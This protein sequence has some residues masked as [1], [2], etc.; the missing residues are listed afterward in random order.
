MEQPP[1]ALG[2]RCDSR[3]E[4]RSPWK[5][6]AVRKNVTVTRYP[7]WVRALRGKSGVYLVRDRVTKQVIYVGRGRTCIKK[8]IVR[9][10]QAW[11]DRN[12]L[13][14][15]YALFDREAVEVKVYCIRPEWVIA[16]EADLIALHKPTL[17]VRR[18]ESSRTRE[19]GDDD[20]EIDR[21]EFDNDVDEV[22]F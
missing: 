12:R 21:F 8:S 16:T 13:W 18:E 5:T 4:W 11:Q 2:A 10:F 17:N 15:H 20:D 1:R 9:H 19:P 7:V 14:H 22:P 3:S 6:D